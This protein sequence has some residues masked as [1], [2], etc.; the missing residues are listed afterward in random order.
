VRPRSERAGSPRPTD[1]RRTRVGEKTVGE[2][3][4]ETVET[5][6]EKTEVEKTEDESRERVTRKCAFTA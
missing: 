2:T 4:G 5:V 1:G 3:V 6:D